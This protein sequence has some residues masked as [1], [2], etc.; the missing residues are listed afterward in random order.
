MKDTVD[1]MATNAEM[2]AD[3]AINGRHMNGAAE[4]PDEE[5][6]DS[7]GSL[8]GH[9]TP[10]IAA[11]NR[12]PRLSNET[13]FER[14]KQA[15]GFSR[16][17]SLR[18]DFADALDAEEVDGSDQQFTAEER[19][20]LRNI[21]GLRE[22]R[23]EDA[24][25][26]RAD[27][28][29]V[30]QSTKLAEILNI[31]KAAGHSR[32]PVYNDVL[33]EP[34]GMV[35]VKDITNSITQTARLTKADIAKRK[36]PLP[37]DLDLK[38]VKL[39]KA[40]SETRLVRPVLFVPP[41]MP[42]LDL[43][44][45]M[46]ATR[47]HMAIVV[48][49][50]GGTDGL[51]TIEDLMEEIVGDIEDEHDQDEADLIKKARDGGLIVNARASL[52]DLSKAL[53]ID[54]LTHEAAEEVDTLGGFVFSLIGRVPVRGEIVPLEGPFEVEVLDA[55]P[56]RIKR[57]KIVK[58]AVAPIEPNETPLPEPTLGRSSDGAQP[59]A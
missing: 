47:I 10:G 13:F 35:H 2:Q 4:N 54:L 59:N 52:D 33:D 43:L 22:R 49:E 7:P 40:L 29:A 50:Y 36:I 42:A 11:L 16:E 38:K 21:L 51:V 25:V 8:N 30:E 20:L 26:P 53:D 6:G 32:I 17:T 27:I 45:K 55:D 46:Q 58:T 41:S 48:D 34:V 18:D 57:V 44:A 28:I 9:A 12:A 31:F 1:S 15:L 14:L 24:M 56:R 39:D 23:V 3:D 5:V 19:A 37:G